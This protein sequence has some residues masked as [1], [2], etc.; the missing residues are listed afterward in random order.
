MS[1]EYSTSANK[2][3]NT[4]CGKKARSLSRHQP[5]KAVDYG[6]SV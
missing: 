1:E 4:I 6:V 5:S 2:L 3:K